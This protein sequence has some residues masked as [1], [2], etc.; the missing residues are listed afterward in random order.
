MVP[1]C[2]R[3]VTAADR[4]FKVKLDRLHFSVSISKSPDGIERDCF[5][6]LVIYI[7]IYIYVCVFMYI[8]RYICL[9]RKL[10]HNIL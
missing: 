7:Y 2:S 9:L 3:S 6:R 1:T 4:L 8:H 5:V 10:C